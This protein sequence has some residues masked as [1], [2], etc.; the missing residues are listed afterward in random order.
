MNHLCNNL[1]CVWCFTPE[2]DQAAFFIHTRLI[3]VN[4]SLALQTRLLDLSACLRLIK[5]L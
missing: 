5:V 4:V 2:E 3:S 1:V